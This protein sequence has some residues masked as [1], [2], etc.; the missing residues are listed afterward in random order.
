MINQLIIFDFYTVAK[1]RYLQSC[2]LIACYQIRETI[3]F[4]KRKNPLQ[5]LHRIFRAEY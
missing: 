4:C 1:E 2:S 5:K 3:P